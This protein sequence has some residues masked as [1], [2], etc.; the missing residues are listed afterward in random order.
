VEENKYFEI[1]KV[2]PW[3]G[4]RSG[5]VHTPHGT[6]E[7]PIFMPCGTN[8]TLKALTFDQVNDCGAQII[9]GNS[10]HLYLRPGL[11]IIKQFGGLH[12][13]ANWSKPI[14]TDSGGFQVFSLDTLRK[15]SDAGVV[16]KD[17]ISGQ[18][19]F[20]G[21]KESMHIQNIIGADIIMAFDECV[22]NPATHEE[23][24]A[25]MDRTHR[26][27]EQCVEH[28][29]SN[30][31]Q[32]LF[33]IIQGST[34][35]DLRELS[36]K[37]VTSYD[38]PGFAIGGVA[39]GEE[40][41]AIEHITAFTAK[42]MPENKPRYIMGIGTPW[43]IAYAI[44]CGIDMFD[45]VSPTRLARHGAAFASEGRL[46]LK[47]SRFATDAKPLDEEC[48]CYTCKNH[49]RAYLHHLVR[50]KEM[51]ASTLLSIHN[52]RFLLN[53]AR[54]CRQAINQG[55]F[56]SLFEHYA[57]LYQGEENKS[58]ADSEEI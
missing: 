58:S 24:T 10:Y 18:E 25:A 50:I 51:T 15:I 14:L 4:A 20:I 40:R 34:Y 28:H 48:D 53:I 38:L 57:N 11:D 49:S 1:E 52:I 12:K 16:F 31:G 37:T 44:K 30:N 46:S 23:A 21:P 56:Q 45:C 32:A 19:H 2:C 7:T 42:F 47:A 5:R 55:T 39:V 9:L 35:E 22:K 27:L 29:Q 41:K 6:F 8:G 3:S 13:F 26:W 36:A 17:H 43:D 54:K 33:G